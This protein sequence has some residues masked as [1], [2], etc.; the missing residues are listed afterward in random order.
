MA[1]AFINC[2]YSFGGQLNFFSL[3]FKIL[4]FL[5]PKEGPMD[6]YLVILFDSEGHLLDFGAS[7]S[8]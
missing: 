6:P 4:V 1:I 8:L 3:A 7:K 2:M 5:E